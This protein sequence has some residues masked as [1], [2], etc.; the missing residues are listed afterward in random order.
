MLD[1]QQPFNKFFRKLPPHQRISDNY[2]V[3]VYTE[4]FESL[5]DIFGA[6]DPVNIEDFLDIEKK[7]IAE[8]GF[9]DR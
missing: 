9:C 6:T 7:D 2:Y 4:D 1:K 3:E 8:D 5:C